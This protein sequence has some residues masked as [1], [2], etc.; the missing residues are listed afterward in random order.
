MLATQTVGFS[1]KQW[2]NN[3]LEVLRGNIYTQYIDRRGLFS[4]NITIPFLSS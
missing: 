3:N 4:D 2:M 1:V